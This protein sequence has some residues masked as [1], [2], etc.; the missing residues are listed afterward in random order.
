MDKGQVTAKQCVL[1]HEYLGLFLP[2]PTSCGT[3]QA[4]VHAELEELAFAVIIASLHLGTSMR[5][6]D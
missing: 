2:G 5:L 3:T 6:N 1:H 4:P